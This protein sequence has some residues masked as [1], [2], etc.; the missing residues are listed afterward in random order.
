M[1]QNK[2]YPEN[3]QSNL[4][5]TLIEVIAVLVIIGILSIMVSGKISMKN[6]D[7]YAIES[8]LKNHI[9]YTQSKAMLSDT[10]IWG[11]R[12]DTA[13][14]EYWLFQ[15]NLGANN[16]WATNRRLPP[17]GEASASSL[18]DRVKTSLMD[19][20]LNGISVGG[21]SKT[22]LTLVYNEMGVPFW[23]E[24]AGVTFLDPLSD[25]TGLTRLTTDI[26]IALQDNNGNTRTVSISS[27]TGFVR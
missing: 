2:N 1:S 25:T 3:Q 26:T 22:K 19:V 15:T 17:G 21:G 13:S 16:G 18:T 12:L 23:L 20:D 8:A 7:L 10:S 4:G 5:F 14:D 9:R 11:I 24:G 27:E 6:T